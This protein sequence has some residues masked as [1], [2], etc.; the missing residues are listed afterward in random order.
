MS[1]FQFDNLQQYSDVL[2]LH[3]GRP[4]TLRFVE[5]DDAL[6]LQNY[7]RGLSQ[8]SRHSRFLG[9]LSELP[10]P[11][12]DEFIHPGQGDRFSVI[13]VM[14]IDGFETI[15]G[16]ARYGFEADTGRFEFGLS[17]DDRWQGQG[18]G[19]ALVSGLA[20]PC[21]GLRVILL[22]NLAG[23]VAVTHQYLRCGVAGICPGQ[24][25]RVNAGILDVQSLCKP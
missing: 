13:A 2:R 5:P 6:A 10:G 1:V 3:D 17:I 25:G 11:L 14:L 4:V 22:D 7:F 21:G 8:R 20:V 16:E 12:L 24:Q 23:F 19:A 15:V 9:T 18:I